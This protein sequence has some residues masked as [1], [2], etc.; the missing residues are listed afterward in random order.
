MH[1][2]IWSNLVPFN[3]PNELKSLVIYFPFFNLNQRQMQ[4]E[5]DAVFANHGLFYP[6]KVI[7]NCLQTINDNYFNLATNFDQ[8]H[9]TICPLYDDQQKWTFNCFQFNYEHFYFPNFSALITKWWQLITI[10]INQ[11]RWQNLEQKVLLTNHYIKCTNYQATIII[12][13][14]DLYYQTDL[15]TINHQIQT[16][17]NHQIKTIIYLETTGF[18]IQLFD[19]INQ[20]TNQRLLTPDHFYHQVQI[21]EQELKLIVHN[22]LQIINSQSYRIEHD[23]LTNLSF[24]KPIS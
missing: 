19:W 18:K 1:R 2:L 15:L 4:S 23:V 6:T 5:S 22:Q 3:S 16:L 12:F 13:W 21:N 8:N 11:N 10:I 20:V 7:I 17:I 9:L 24:V 14:S